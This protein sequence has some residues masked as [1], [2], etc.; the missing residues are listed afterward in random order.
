[1]N[2]EPSEAELVAETPHFRTVLRL[3]YEQLLTT[4]KKMLAQT[5]L[6]LRSLRSCI[7][8]P[9]VRTSSQSCVRSSI[10][11]YKT[12]DHEEQLT[13]KFTVCPTFERALM[14]RCD[15]ARHFPPARNV[16][17]HRK[18]YKLARTVFQA[19]QWSQLRYTS[20]TATPQ[21]FLTPMPFFLSSGSTVKGKSHRYIS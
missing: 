20:F 10:R 17:P 3:W 5:R 11:L 4:T 16:T 12:K 19:T 14:R 6:R 21:Y 8:L 1:M 18:V 2:F 7:V 15:F 9:S 13:A